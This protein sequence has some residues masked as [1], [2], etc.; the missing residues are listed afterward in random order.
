MKLPDGVYDVLKWIS[1]IFLPALSVLLSTILPLYHIDG[2]IVKIVVITIN[3][4]GVF[5]G[6]LIGISQV[7][8]A[9]DSS[10]KLKK[11]ANGGEEA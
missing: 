3:A 2:E 7:K 4:I 9:Q 8:I 11:A 5:I 1:I 10:K 6:T